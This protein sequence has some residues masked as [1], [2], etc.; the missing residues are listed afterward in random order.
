MTEAILRLQH[1]QFEGAGL[2]RESTQKIPLAKQGRVLLAGQEGSGKS[3]IP[4]V[5]TLVLY[6]KGSPRLR[7]SGLV[8]SSIVNADIG[9]KGELAFESGSGASRREVSIVQAFKH[10]RLKSRYI[11]TVDGER[12]EPTTKP[13]QKKLVKRLAPLSYEEWLGVVY[14][15]QGGVHDLLAGSPTEK[16][17]Y[18]T[19]VFGLDFYDDLLTEAKEEA[20]RLEK[21]ASGALDLEQ[22]LAD[23]TAR[24]KETGAQLDDLP[25]I[26]DIDE[27][28][29]TLTARMKEASSLLGSLRSTMDDAKKVA[30]MDSELSALGVTDPKSVLEALNTEKTALVDK[31]A[32]LRAQLTEAKKTNDAHSAAKAR[33]ASAKKK[34]DAGAA[35]A[36]ELRTKTAGYLSLEDLEQLQALCTEASSLKV[37]ALTP[38]K[39]TGDWREYAQSALSSRDTA[40]K[41]KAFKSKAHAKHDDV[42][43]PTCL[44]SLPLE[45]LD[46]S[47]SALNSE[48]EKADKKAGTCLRHELLKLMPDLSAET[49]EEV[50]NNVEKMLEGLESLASAEEEAKTT[51]ATLVTEQESFNSVAEPVD[52]DGITSEVKELDADI[53]RVEKSVTTASKAKSLEDKIAAIGRTDVSDVESRLSQQEEKYKKAKDKHDEVQALR[54]EASQL[55]AVLSSLKKQKSQVEAQI[56][57]HAETALLVKAYDDE[58]VPFFTSLRAAK[59]K[60]CVSI[61]E[62]VLPVYIASMSSSQYDG[63]E[64]KLSVSDDLKDVDLS[65]RV[66]R[67]MPWISAVQASGGQRRRFTLAILAALRE[68]SPRKSNIMFFDEPFADL[69]SEGKLMFVNR[70][71]PLLMDR[72]PDLESLFLIAHDQEVLQA[73]NDAFDSVWT[74]ERDERGSRIITGQ[75]LSMVA[76]R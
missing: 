24:L 6:G 57:K 15:H 32:T 65:L 1:L 50:Q 33:L 2:Y 35:K 76:G 10:A 29:E 12:E 68:V 62:G 9:Y 40:R 18:L 3:M 39:A 66:G 19:S 20:R 49:V 48:A 71:V 31:R 45:Q 37:T 51:A 43:C 69:E 67:G 74:A 70:L 64:I 25:P 14:L 23:V 61:L 53:A 8:E 41:L 42:E 44:R 17:E 30:Q 27:K 54:S 46:A 52:T 11:I 58:L 34:A 63:A 26:E 55:K 16:R 28:L 22:T 38:G 59:V 60:S 73:G 21:S 5:M 7:K 36:L 75:K 72:C 56:A 47:I 4:E 13:E